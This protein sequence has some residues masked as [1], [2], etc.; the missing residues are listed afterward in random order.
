MWQGEGDS[1]RQIIAILGRTSNG[2]NNVLI[3]KIS[4]SIRPLSASNRTL[5]IHTNFSNDRFRPLWQE[6]AFIFHAVEL[7]PALRGY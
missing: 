6:R 7:G 2:A 5:N 3:L 1:H 4:A